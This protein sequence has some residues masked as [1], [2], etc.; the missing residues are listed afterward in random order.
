[1]V[2]PTLGGVGAVGLLPGMRGLRWRN[3]TPALDVWNTE[4]GA[5]PT[6]SAL[7]FGT[8]PMQIGSYVEIGSLVV[9][10][11]QIYLGSASTNAG[12]GPWIV[13][14]PVPAEREQL[15][16]GSAASG[17]DVPPFPADKPIGSGMI[18]PGGLENQ[19][20]PVTICMSDYP[21]LS[22]GG[23]RDSWAHAFIPYCLQKGTGSFSASTTSAI[24][25]P[26]ALPLFSVAA[27]DLTITMTSDT[28]VNA[29]RTPW[30]SGGTKTG[31]TVN[32]A[33]AISASYSWQLFNVTNA[34]LLQQGAPYGLTTAVYRGT[35]MYERKR[36]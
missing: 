24:T 9:A 6:P 27:N 17:F 5:G 15:G 3:W 11:F 25:F 2:Y 32:V 1:V 26:T 23:D 10:S 33:S 20:V 8:N 35:L 14:L 7:S 13:R 18:F 28:A 34:I 22:L 4:F 29:A 36:N 12:A 16:I 19:N 21:G 30:V 31:F